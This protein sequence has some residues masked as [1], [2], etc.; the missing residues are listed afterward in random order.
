MLP[1][2]LAHYYPYDIKTH[3]IVCSTALMA[4]LWS[5]DCRFR[6]TKHETIILTERRVFFKAIQKAKRRVLPEYTSNP[7]YP[8]YKGNWTQIGGFTSYFCLWGGNFS[9]AVIISRVKHIK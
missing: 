9:P 8:E 6:A 2:L 5:Y 4:L 1:I 7:E 3:F